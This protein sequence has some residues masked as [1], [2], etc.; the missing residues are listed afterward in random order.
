MQTTSPKLYL[1]KYKL[2]VYKYKLY[3]SKYN[4]GEVVGS[5]LLRVLY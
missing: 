3:L 1:P 4:L 5:W 2:G